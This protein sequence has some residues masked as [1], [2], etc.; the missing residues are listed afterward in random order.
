MG[1]GEERPQFAK[2][3]TLSCNTE[4]SLREYYYLSGF[5][6]KGRGDLGWLPFKS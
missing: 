4:E 5:N 3:G 2:L 1:E 6:C